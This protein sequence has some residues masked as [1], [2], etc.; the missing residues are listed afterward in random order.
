MRAR[1][2]ENIYA[3]YLYKLP[4]PHHYRDGSRTGLL[5]RVHPEGPVQ[6]CSDLEWHVLS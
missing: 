2:Q 6:T 5:T 3:G 4:Y 1:F